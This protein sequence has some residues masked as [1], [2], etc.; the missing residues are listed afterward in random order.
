MGQKEN[1]DDFLKR[2]LEDDSVFEFNEA[3]WAKAETLIANN[4]NNKIA[5]FSAKKIVGVLSVLVALVMYF[6][7]T[8]ITKNLSNT[9]PGKTVSEQKNLNQKVID[10]DVKASDENKRKKWLEAVEQLGKKDS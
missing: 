5:Y 8:N 4:Q 6:V 9:K 7:S 2:N 3:D 1:L 10:S